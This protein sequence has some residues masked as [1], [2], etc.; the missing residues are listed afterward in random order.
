M[1]EA[2]RRERLRAQDGEPLRPPQTLR[3][4]MAGGALAP[5]RL[6]EARVLWSATRDRLAT[7][8]SDL[9]AAEQL[10][11]LTLLLSQALDEGD[12]G[13]ATRVRALT[14]GALEVMML[15]RFRQ[16][17]RGLLARAAARAGDLRAADAWLT[18]CDPASE[19]LEMDSAYRISR[20]Y[21]ATA[22]D[23]A[24]TVLDALGERF[25]Q[26]PIQ[27]AL[28]ELAAVL[29]AHA[30][31]RRGDL[32]RAQA[33]LVAVLSRGGH[34]AVDAVLASLPKQWRVC[35]QSHPGALEQTRAQVAARTSSGRAM[36]VLFSLVI[37]VVA[38]APV[39]ALI[40]LVRDGSFRPGHLVL[41]IFPAFFGSMAFH[42]IRDALRH[43]T[44]ATRGLP[45]KGTILSYETSGTQIHH[46][47][48][49]SFTVRCEIPG[50]PPTEATTQRTMYPGEASDMVG[51]SVTIL[52][53][54][55]HP[56]DVVVDW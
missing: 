31:E 43:R 15:P 13:Q 7:N 30:W 28:E 10:Y 47:P 20:A 24:L 37:S 56:Q 2:G 53:D 1:D 49:I 42:G 41:L 52:W 8:P 14:E 55:E 32:A 51:R 27:D 48:V 21:L 34:A 16:L 6:Q 23:D 4:L 25:D 36:N 19:D 40:Q 12:R 38:I 46:V 33:E 50:Y 17:L 44:I 54:P 29:R 3:P 9:P 5:H 35:A 22:R 18:G 11:V 45:G 26:I 39:A